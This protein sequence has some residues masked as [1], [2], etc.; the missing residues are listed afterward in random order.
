MQLARAQNQARLAWRQLPQLAARA[1]LS[2]SRRPATARLCP[3]TSRLVGEPC[4]S[5][6]RVLYW[7]CLAVFVTLRVV[8]F[9]GPI[10]LCRLRDYVSCL[11]FSSSLRSTPPPVEI[12]S[13]L[14]PYHHD[15]LLPNGM[16][17]LSSP[18]GSDPEGY[19]ALPHRARTAFSLL[20]I[21]SSPLLSHGGTT[22]SSPVTEMGSSPSSRPPW[23]Y[24]K[25]SVGGGSS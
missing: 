1:R 3:A 23:R 22:P 11:L 9:W 6:V 20:E 14:L 4:P 16:R 15:V 24:S 13:Y 19:W 7:W 18:P 8:L 12:G 21:N 25:S 2:S 5:E 10:C 17:L